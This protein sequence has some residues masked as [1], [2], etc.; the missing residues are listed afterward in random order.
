MYKKSAAIVKYVLARFYDDK[1]AWFAASPND[2]AKVTEALSK[3]KE[4]FDY[5]LVAK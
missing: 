1:N 4:K 5:K 2:K 3:I